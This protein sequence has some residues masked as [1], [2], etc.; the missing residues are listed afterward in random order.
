MRLIDMLAD[1]IGEAYNTLVNNPKVADTKKAFGSSLPVRYGNELA[2]RFSNNM[3]TAMDPTLPYQLKPESTF[4]LAGLALTSSL[5]FAP[6]G[7]NVVGTVINPLRLPS[8]YGTDQ[9]LG[10]IQANMRYST[11]EEA[12]LGH[13]WDKGGFM[14][15]SR[16]PLEKFL[17]TGPIDNFTH[18]YNNGE[19][20]GLM[21]MPGPRGEIGS[22]SYMGIDDAMQDMT[23]R[24][25]YAAPHF[26]VTAD[27]VFDPSVPLFVGDKQAPRF[28]PA[29]DPY[30]VYNIAF[31][32]NN[33]TYKP[34]SKSVYNPI[35]QKLIAE[36][37]ELR[38]NHGMY[39]ALQSR[40]FD[41]AFSIPPKELIKRLENSDAVV[42]VGRSP[43]Y[44]TRTEGQFAPTKIHPEH[45][46]S[47]NTTEN[48]LKEV[49]YGIS[50]IE[51]YG[52]ED[53]INSLHS[54]EYQIL[55]DTP[56]TWRSGA[57]ASHPLYEHGIKPNT[58]EEVIV[59][60]KP[61][62][63]PIVTPYSILVKQK[64]I[65]HKMPIWQYLE[66]YFKHGVTPFAVG[67]IMLNN[68]K[69]NKQ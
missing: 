64:D 48:F 41:K 54:K 16:M 17:Q 14:P 18:F 23:M 56:A 28:N 39:D 50:D 65:E 38:G 58:G 61:S 7:N 12:L 15:V 8:Q 19:V 25:K 33:A 5:P 9:L 62:A 11:L 53:F 47:Y 30:S 36:Q 20:K 24:L 42:D 44:L 40:I 59:K 55:S 13:L 49:N 29:A 27:T 6:K 60:T 43:M 57:S 3:A 34:D 66:H 46:N 45:Y 67:G 31:D 52:I 35:Y 63:S 26:G 4:G 1:H 22:V 37:A 51:R 10:Q 68:S 21:K 2:N 69:E 32:A